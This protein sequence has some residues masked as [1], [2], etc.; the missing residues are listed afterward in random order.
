VLKSRISRTLSTVATA[1]IAGMLSIP[2][3]A[4]AEDNAPFDRAQ[5]KRECERRGGTFTEGKN[6]EGKTVW[7]CIHNGQVIAHCEVDD[8]GYGGCAGP[9][10][11]PMKIEGSSPAGSGSRP[12]NAGPAQHISEGPFSPAS[13]AGNGIRPHYIGAA[14][15][16]GQDT[17]RASPPS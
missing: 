7:M 16:S 1:L 13:S 17:S 6:S 15:Y 11:W 5:F 12:H 8:E 14:Q 2:A 3:A 9:A 10:D 4:S